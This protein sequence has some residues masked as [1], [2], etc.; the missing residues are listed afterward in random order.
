MDGMKSSTVR[1]REEDEMQEK[2]CCNTENRG[3]LVQETT[4]MLSTTLFGDIE[5]KQCSPGPLV[6]SSD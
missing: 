6:Y 2:N 4:N 3:C 1:Q 5:H